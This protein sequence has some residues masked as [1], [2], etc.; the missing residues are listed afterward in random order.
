M[1]PHE[2]L[3]QFKIVGKEPVSALNNSMG[4]VGKLDTGYVNTG[5]EKLHS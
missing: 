3:M 4:C 2:L 1:S 5:K